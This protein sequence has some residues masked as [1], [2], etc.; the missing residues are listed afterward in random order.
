MICKMCGSQIE[1]GAVCCSICGSP[2]EGTT[3][4]N[5]NNNQ[6]VVGN[7]VSTNNSVQSNV[8][9]TEKIKKEVNDRVSVGTIILGIFIPIVGFVL[10][11]FIKKN[12][13]KKAKAL[14]ISSIISGV[15]FYLPGVIATFGSVFI[16]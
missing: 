8:P 2:I 7:N 11:F 1:E 13:P 3:A 16:Q 15:I 9:V 4:N 10:S 5:L 14:L 6:N 12:T